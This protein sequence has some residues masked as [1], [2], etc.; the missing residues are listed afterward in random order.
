MEI[1][2]LEIQTIQIAQEAGEFIAKHFDQITKDDI[3]VKG[4]NSLVSFVD[5]GAERIIVEGLNNLLPDAGFITEEETVSQGSK[6]LTWIIDPLDGTT[7]FIHGIPH[8]SVSI[9]LYDGNNVIVGVVHDVMKN[10][11]FHASKGGGSFLS[12]SAISVTSERNF[13]DMVIG[14][15]FP[16]LEKH[17]LPGHFRALS[18][19][20][21]KTRGVRRMGSAAL[22]LC[23]VAW[24]RFG[25]FYEESLNAYDIAAGALIVQEAGGLISDY[26]GGDNWLWEGQI[27]ACSQACN[28]SMLEILR[29]FYQDK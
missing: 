25:A 11:T 29:D 12:G 5:Q 15:G 4:H 14:T 24:G 19:V 1:K 10:Q 7:N 20:L 16:Y 8:F 18:Q 13:S 28:E 9:A 17:T 23:M 22:D 2:G 27:L 3:I 21:N 26:S 6:E